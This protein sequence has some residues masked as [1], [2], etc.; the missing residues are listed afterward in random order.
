MN[1]NVPACSKKRGREALKSINHTV[2]SRQPKAACMVVNA[3]RQCSVAETKLLQRG[4]ILNIC[5]LSGKV[6]VEDAVD[7]CH[8]VLKAAFARRSTWCCEGF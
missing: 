5:H 2:D 3:E 6:A 7:L 4:E 8:Q 1:T